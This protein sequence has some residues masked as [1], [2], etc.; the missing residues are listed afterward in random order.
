MVVGP[1]APVALRAPSASGPTT[2]SIS[3]PVRM[4]FI[5]QT[6]PRPYINLTREVVS[7]IIGTGG[8]PFSRICTVRILARNLVSGNTGDQVT[9]DLPGLDDKSCP[10]LALTSPPP[11]GA[12]SVSLYFL[13][14]TVLSHKHRFP[15][16]SWRLERCWIDRSRR[17][18]SQHDWCRTYLHNSEF[19]WASEAAGSRGWHAASSGSRPLRPSCYSAFVLKHRNRVKSVTR[20]PAV[21]EPDWP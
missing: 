5:H 7:Q 3:T 19:V 15:T 1:K 12:M 13:L 6:L 11:V 16:V 9:Q 14:P 8:S 4:R 10:P 17:N 20:C 2:T 18:Y 21:R